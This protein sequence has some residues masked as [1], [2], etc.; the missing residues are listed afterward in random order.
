ML[1]EQVLK[2]YKEGYSIKW[3]LKQAMRIEKRNNSAFS[4]RDIHLWIEHIIV[5]YWEMESRKNK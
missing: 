5:E 3:I 1:K 2:F 4:S